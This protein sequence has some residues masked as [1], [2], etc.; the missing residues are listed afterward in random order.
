M[1]STDIL[2]AP[3][4]TGLYGRTFRPNLVLFWLRTTILVTNRRIA[5]KGPNTILGVIPLGYEERSMPIRSV[6]GVTSSLSVAVVRL[7]VF[8]ILTLFSVV[9]LFQTLKHG[10]A[11]MIMWLLFTLVLGALTANS[12]TGKLSVT[13]SG[14]GTTDTTVSAF[15]MAGLESFKNRANEIVYSAGEGGSSWNQA[16]ADGF[17]GAPN[18]SP[19]QYTEP[20]GHQPTRPDAD[21]PSTHGRFAAPRYDE[22][23]H[24][25][26]GHD[27]PRYGGPGHEGP[28]HDGPGREA[29]NY[30]GPGRAPG[31]AP[32][33][34][35]SRREDEGSAR[36]GF[37]WVTDP[38][39]RR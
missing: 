3:G 1:N 32:Q 37:A 36:Y 26:P 7:M 20:S 5:V 8:G 17:D 14:G 39:E 28:R 29:P 6:A 16:M 31:Y 23:R 25:G 33:P 10:D 18:A 21:G 22:P 27:S 12:V 35:G 34:D 24:D 15:E 4:E 19:L 30:S 38:S 2:L 11:M 13:N 9:L